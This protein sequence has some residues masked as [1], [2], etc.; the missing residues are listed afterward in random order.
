MAVRY[1]GQL[2]IEQRVKEVDYVIKT[3]SH[4]KA[5]Q[6]CHINMLKA[7]YEQEPVAAVA[8]A[9]QIV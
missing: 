4:R 2:I 9:T 3:P 1:C 6:L 8:I 7:Y 5:N